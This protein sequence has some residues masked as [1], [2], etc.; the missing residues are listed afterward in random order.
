MAKDFYRTLGISKTAS[1]KEVKQA[2]RRLAKQ[3]HPDTNPDNPQAEARFKEISEAYE[4]LSDSEKRS[5]YDQFGADFANFQGF[6]GF[7]QQR[8]G[9]NRTNVDFGNADFQNIMDSFFGFGQQ[10]SNARSQAHPRQSAGQNIEH[11]ISIDLRE[12]YEGTTRLI[13]KGERQIRVN[14]PAGADNGT[15]VRLT[16][17]GEGGFGGGKAGDLLLIVSVEADPDFER[18]GDNLT[19]EIKV[20]MFTALLGGEVK[21][22]T[23]ARPVKLKIPAGT[24]SGQKFRLTGKGMPKLRKK[25]EFGDLYARVLITVPESLT[26]EQQRLVEDLRK[27]IG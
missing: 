12:A 17:E 6:Q 25:G 11:G 14:I 5:Q 1:D 24:Q 10:R 15:K 20:N 19:T 18:T 16:G 2:Y 7:N 26:D 27:S 3:Y 21:I 8:G 13:T 22:P 9:Q 23:L 4:V